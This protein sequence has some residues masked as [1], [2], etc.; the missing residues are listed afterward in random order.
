ME[1]A[2]AEAAEAALRNEV[3][4]GAVVVDPAAGVVLAS[5]GN[6]TEELSDAT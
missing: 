5:A 2:L 4:V 6:R 1:L 3:P